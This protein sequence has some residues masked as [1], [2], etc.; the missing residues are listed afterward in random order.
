M[1]TKKPDLTR[2][3]LLD[4]HD[5]FPYVHS[6]HTDLRRKFQDMGMDFKDGKKGQ[7]EKVELE[8]LRLFAQRIVRGALEGPSDIVISKDVY[9]EALEGID[10]ISLDKDFPAAEEY[11][12]T[13]IVV[14]DSSARMGG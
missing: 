14:T 1:D 12:G 9:F 11:L 10:G 3:R 13:P 7:T 4:R 5:P 6:S 8:Q 2:R